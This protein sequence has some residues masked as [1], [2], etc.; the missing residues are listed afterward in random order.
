MF[1]AGQHTHSLTIRKSNPPQ[2][3]RLGTSETNRR[4][5][6]D[7]QTGNPRSGSNSPI[8]GESRARGGGA[9]QRHKERQA[10]LERVA[11]V[12]RREAG[13]KRSRVRVALAIVEVARGG[14]HVDVSE[15][16]APAVIP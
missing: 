15:M 2:S 3:S 7:S 4:P 11:V 1:S 9:S 13:G 14:G 12:R 10:D 6:S 16:V 5:S 8:S